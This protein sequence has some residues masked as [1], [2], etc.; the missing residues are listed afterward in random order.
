[1]YGHYVFIY[2]YIHVVYIYMCIYICVCIENKKRRMWCKRSFIERERECML[3]MYMYIC[4]YI[5]K[6]NIEYTVYIY[7]KCIFVYPSIDVF[8]T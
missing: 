1:M 7:I 6:K 2:I 5:G 4:V 3:Y 8:V